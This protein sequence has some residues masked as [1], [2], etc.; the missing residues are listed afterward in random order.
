[1][2]KFKNYIPLHLHSTYSIGDGVSKIEDIIKRAKEIGSNSI[3]ISEHGT[4]AS[5]YKFYLAAKSN[6]INPIIGCEFYINDLYF[7]DNE[8]FLKIKRSKDNSS[9]DLEGDEDNYDKSEAANSHLIVYAKNFEGLKNIIHLNNIA[10]QNFY[11]KPLISTEHV[12]NILDE[13]NIVTTACLASKF[14]KLILKN[15]LNEVVD[16]LKK[17]KNKFKDDFYIEYH[18]NELKEQFK[19]NKF[20]EIASKK[21]KIPLVLG[22]DAHYVYKEDWKIQYLLYVIKTRNTVNTMPESKWFYTI[23]DLYIKTVDEIYDKA[24]LLNYNIDAVNEAIGSTFDIANKVNIEIPKNTNN[25]PKFFENYEDSVDTFNKK[26]ET[27]WDEKVKNGLIPN[28]KI[29]QYRERLEQERKLM[30]D[31]GYIDYFLIL[32]DLLNNFV[33]KTGG[34]SGAGRGSASGS[35]ILFILDITK[36][37]PLKYDLI[38]ERFINEAR[39]DPPDVDCD[40]DHITQKKVENYLIERWGH[41]KV[42]HIGSFGKFGTK[43]LIKDICRVYELDFNLSNQLTALFSTT[44]SDSDIKTELENAYNIAQKTNNY[45]LIDFIDK[46]KSLFIEL[47]DKMTGMIRQ[48]NRHASGI[49]ISDKTFENSDI[50]ITYTKGNLIT[51]VQEGGDEREVSELGYLKLDI[52]GL[53]TATINGETIKLIEKNYNIKNLE[54][55]LLLSNFDDA[56]V[57]KEFGIGNSK[58]IFQFGSDSMIELMK[59]IKPNSIQ[60]LSAINALFR[61]A[62]IQ[63]N[64]VS[65]YIKNRE[66][67]NKAKREYDKISKD[68]WPLFKETF[69]IPLYQ[70]SI[71]LILQKIGGFTLAEADKARKTLKLLHKGNQDKSEAF[72]KMIDKFKVQAINNGLSEEGTETLLHKLA[73]YTEYSFN[74]CLS[75]NTYVQTINGI[76]QISDFLGDEIVTSVDPIT[77]EIYQTKVKKLHKNG[78]KRLYSIK[79]KTGKVIE[80]TLDHKFMIKSGE[81]KTLKEIIENNYK[82]CVIDNDKFIKLDKNSLK[83]IGY[84]ETF[85]LE[86]DDKNHN[87]VLSNGIVTSNSHSVA[88]AMNAYVS[89]WLKVHYPKEYYATLLNYTNIDEISIFIKQAALQNIKIGSCTYGNSDNKFTVDYKNNIIRFGLNLVKGLR[90]ND[91]EKINNNSKIKDKVILIKFIIDSKFNKK[92]VE[93]LSRLGYFSN[94]ISDNNLFTEKLLLKLKNSKNFDLELNT[95]LKYEPKFAN[96]QK[97]EIL[98]FE[99]EYLGF[100]LSEHP[101]GEFYNKLLQKNIAK[102]YIRPKDLEEISNKKQNISLVALLGDIILL[103]SKKT[104]KEYYKL[105]LEDDEVQI[106]VTIFD[107]ELIKNLNK[108]D[109]INII[110]NKDNFGYS[111]VKNEQIKI[112]K[113]DNE[114]DFKNKIIDFETI[115]VQQRTKRLF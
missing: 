21:L 65:E 38:F 75:G 66:N 97:Y 45:D 103:K 12:F 5:F 37:D 115:N 18:I 20:Y 14:N 105:V 4:M 106:N 80:C 69:G 23:R 85:D 109:F 81:M 59:Q 86:I 19:V 10:A 92:T 48:Q 28:D 71:M 7:S 41:D 73:A 68:I 94:I 96:Y 33:Y 43:S 63:N 30:I 107:T 2:R 16:L 42:C 88:Y 55:Q 49:L 108:G 102:N 67:P 32:D 50:P 89:Q 25:F 77:K 72:L 17:F 35:L 57:Y 84:K 76:K 6:N 82:I 52:L 34:S 46:N 87:F 54:N 111:V 101:F 8:K 11:R 78:I 31:K 74:K 64:S 9:D 39:I 98:Q 36:I 99:K 40:I 114:I 56:N 62:L 47:C 70:E 3:A 13:N 27:K 90:A 26:L 113:N 29:K 61:P 22:I 53:I 93:V 79:T 91:V 15:E 100:Y 110:I 44:K 24:E 51:N 58:D 95:Y 60:E 112:F 104:G 83:E 1:M